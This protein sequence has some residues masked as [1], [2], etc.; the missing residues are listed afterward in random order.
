VHK[1]PKVCF[2]NILLPKKA[3]GFIISTEKHMIVE[4]GKLAN[5]PNGGL[6]SPQQPRLRSFGLFHA[7]VLTFI[8]VSYMIRQVNYL[9]FVC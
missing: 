2:A 9:E 4:M 5:P 7:R 3:D 6:V 1:R 8:S